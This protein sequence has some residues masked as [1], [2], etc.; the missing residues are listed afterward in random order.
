M[1]GA[2]TK[3]STVAFLMIGA[4]L[5]FYTVNVLAATSL[6]RRSLKISSQV[7]GVSPVTYTFEYQTG[8]VYSIGSVVLEFCENTPLIGLPC[9]PIPG[10]SVAG[11]TITAQTGIVGYSIEPGVTNSRIVFTRTPS[12]EAPVFSSIVMGN[13][14]NPSNTGT[15][16]A[17]VQTFS[18]TDG[19]G[20]AIEEGGMTFATL[21]P[22][23]FSAYVPPY[24]AFCAAVT[25]SGL[26][27]GSSTGSFIDFGELEKNKPNVATSQ[28]MAQTNADNG[29]VIYATGTPPTS[30]NNIIP[31]MAVRGPSQKGVSQF[32]INLRNNSD[33]DVGN[34]PAGSGTDFPTPDYNSVNQF[35]YTSGDVIHS[36]NTT[37]LGNKVTVS[38]L[39]NVSKNQNPGIYTTTLMY[40]ALANF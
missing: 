30:G 37:T 22:A 24:L 36:T 3:I 5:L 11:A 32:G 21:S 8:S 33:P 35:K 6:D 18:S 20:V 25:I 27:C 34:D 23:S 39:I 38:Y 12:V 9:D 28:F 15:H 1:I 29:Y 17:R 10:F 13:I 26:D 4:L 14:V 19:T 16:F 31:A 7:P 2:K 40:I